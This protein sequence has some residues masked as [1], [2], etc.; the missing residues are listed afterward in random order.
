MKLTYLFI[1][2]L[3][4]F[5]ISC[6][7]NIDLKELE[8]H[9]YTSNKESI[10]SLTWLCDKLG[11]STNSFKQ[12]ALKIDSI[13]NLIY[14]ER[15][16]ESNLI[17]SRIEYVKTEDLT[18]ILTNKNKDIKKLKALYEILQLN[19]LLKDELLKRY[20]RIKSITPYAVLDKELYN[21][22]D[23]IEV[24][25][26]AHASY[27]GILPNVTFKEYNMDEL[28]MTRKN[29]NRNAVCKY[30]VYANDVK[31][32]SIKGTFQIPSPLGGDIT[33]NYAVKVNIK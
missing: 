1:L 2:S 9:T 15:F 27:G 28:K 25:V 8:N 24:T 17:I 29:Y 22:T 21:K 13:N 4:V 32:D 3:N 31:L 18:A 10:Q 6:N 7:S 12:T 20:H 11:A 19:Y 14:Q 30:K 26:Y 16:T 33:Q 23:S 5:C